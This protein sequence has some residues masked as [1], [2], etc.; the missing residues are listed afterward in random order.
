MGA[1]EHIS[2]E[3]DWG[4]EHQERLEIYAWMDLTRFE[5]SLVDLID[6]PLPLIGWKFLSI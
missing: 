6:T 1:I 4:Y 3:S 2:I 5:A